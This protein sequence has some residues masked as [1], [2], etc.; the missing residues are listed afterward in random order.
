[1]TFPK[2]AYAQIEPNGI[3]TAKQNPNLLKNMVHYE[4]FISSSDE[5]IAE[6]FKRLS[7]YTASCRED[8]KAG[9][10]ETFILDNATHLSETRWEYIEKYQEATSKKSGNVDKLAMFGSLGDWMWKFFIKEVVSIPCNVVVTFHQMEE[11]ESDEATGKQRKTGR[12]ISD[13]LGRFRDRAP[14]LFN[15]SLFLERY[16]FGT[17]WV[18]KA[19]CIGPEGAGKSAKNNLGLPEVI[20]DISYSKIMSYLNA[21]RK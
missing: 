15:A 9:R 8:A 21:N 18:F 20:E 10:I 2:W 4:S 11:S 13:T 5:D 7:A 6:T 3:I 19:R 14:G 16:K 17:G 1:M 12:I